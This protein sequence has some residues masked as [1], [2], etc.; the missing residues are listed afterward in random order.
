MATTVKEAIQSHSFFRDFPA[1]QLEPIEEISEIVEYDEGDQ[2]IYTDKP[3]DRFLLILEGNVLIEVESQE[4]DQLP[5]QKLSGG[6]ILG[7]SWLI[8]PHDWEFDASAAT[9]V[10]VV[11]IDG[12]KLR[13]LCED[14]QDLGTRIKSELIDVLAERLSSIRYLLLDIQ[15]TTDEFQQLTGG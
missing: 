12:D 15:Q 7:W 3:A 6:K 1:D 9:D 11:E 10:R 8:S 13:K 5:V 2:I 4:G 14:K